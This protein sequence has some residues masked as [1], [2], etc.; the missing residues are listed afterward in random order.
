LPTCRCEELSHKVKGDMATSIIGLVLT[1]RLP[2]PGRTGARNEI[3]NT[4]SDCIAPTI[5]FIIKRFGKVID[6]W[7]KHDES[8]W[9]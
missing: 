6:L 9:R 3:I 2:R 1:K 4:V 8:Y 7:S 5:R